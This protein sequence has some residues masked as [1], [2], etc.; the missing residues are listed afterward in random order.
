MKK[1][2]ATQ[3]ELSLRIEELK[4]ASYRLQEKRFVLYQ[5]YQTELDHYIKEI[6]ILQKEKRKVSSWRKKE[7]IHFLL[8]TLVLFFGIGI[9]PI[10]MISTLIFCGGGF[11]L[12]VYTG[13]GIY[14]HQKLYQELKI[15]E[16]YIQ[17]KKLPLE[18]KLIEWPNHTL[19]MV[20]VI[21]QQI[22]DCEKKLTS[23]THSTNEKEARF[24]IKQKTKKR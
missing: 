18:E 5:L 23:P 8:A 12:M 10:S 16:Q 13:K 2:Y 9:Q 3:D 17:R 15:Q 1:E 22:H 14:D 11:G 6:M 7:I 20:Q 24:N 4:K 19:K 21:E